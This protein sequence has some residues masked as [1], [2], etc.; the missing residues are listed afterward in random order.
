MTLS[1]NYKESVVKQRA[2]PT[3]LA[4][5]PENTQETKPPDSSVEDV[6]LFK[7]EPAINATNEESP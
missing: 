5:I 2:P 4:M 6:N 1:K 3:E 7:P